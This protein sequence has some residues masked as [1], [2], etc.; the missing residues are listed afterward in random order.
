MSSVASETSASVKFV[1]SEA[2]ES[3]VEELSW[4][5][6]MFSLES[7]ILSRRLI[8]AE[9]RRTSDFKAFKSSSFRAIEQEPS[10]VT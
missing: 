8:A 5:Q 10:G 9:R 3:D 7:G 6:V 2:L 1:A 4:L